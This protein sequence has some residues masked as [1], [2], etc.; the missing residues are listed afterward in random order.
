[1]A[2]SGCD[3]SKRL[4]S[5]QSV[6]GSLKF[7]SKSKRTKQ[8]R[9]RRKRS[10]SNYFQ[11]LREFRLVNQQTNDVC[12]SLSVFNITDMQSQDS[13]SVPPTLPKEVSDWQYFH[14]LAYWKSRATSLEY[15]NKML[16]EH[17]KKMCMKNIE[18]YVAAKEQLEYA[19]TNQIEQ[20]NTEQVTDVGEERLSEKNEEEDYPRQPEVDRKKMF[21]EFE[22]KVSGMETALQV[23]YQMQVDNLKGQMWPNIPLNL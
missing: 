4:K 8:R 5:T 2:D 1:M 23:N 12:A 13:F 10:K 11:S 14:Q 6:F 15:E 17:I 16:H 18:D 3:I 7:I 19:G 9:L 20:S 22:S 21:G